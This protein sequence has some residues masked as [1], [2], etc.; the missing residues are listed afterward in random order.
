[1]NDF[2]TENKTKSL[3]KISEALECAFGVVRKDLDEQQDLMEFI[4]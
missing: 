4:W 1:L 2:F 3:L